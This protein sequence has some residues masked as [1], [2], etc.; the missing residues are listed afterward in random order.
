MSVRIYRE[1]S[2]TSFSC[3]I[4][5]SIENFLIKIFSLSRFGFNKWRDPM[6]PSQ[7][8]A[9][10]CK[11]EG[12]DGPTYTAPGKCKIENHIFSAAVSVVDEAGMYNL[13]SQSVLLSALFES[14]I[15]LK[16]MK[17]RTSPVR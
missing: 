6:K 13:T 14:K 8:L 5:P 10:L 1:G 12:L 2:E 9:R 16:E 11:D 4:V 17:F 3:S 15:V 7:I